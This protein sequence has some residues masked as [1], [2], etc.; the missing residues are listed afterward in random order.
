MVCKKI[1]NKVPAFLLGVLIYLGSIF[2][3]CN[4]LDIDPYIHDLF[5]IDTL[6]A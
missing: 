3:S 2:Q 6:F 4:F 5:T 1:S